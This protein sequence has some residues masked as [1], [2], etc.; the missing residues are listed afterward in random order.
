MKLCAGA[1]FLSLF[2]LSKRDEKYYYD[3]MRETHVRTTHAH[4]PHAA[5]H[6][7]GGGRRRRGRGRRLLPLFF[8]QMFRA[9]F[10]PLAPLL[11]SSSFQE[12]NLFF[13]PRSRACAVHLRPFLARRLR[14]RAKLRKVQDGEEDPF[15]DAQKKRGAQKIK[16]P[17]VKF[18][19]PPH[20]LSRPEKRGGRGNTS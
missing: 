7:K 19:P 11:L 18:S 4:C 12:E 6:K 3:A 8:S 2:P 9:N 17:S 10:R 16:R 15:L 20:S 14:P 5:R 1:S 13:V